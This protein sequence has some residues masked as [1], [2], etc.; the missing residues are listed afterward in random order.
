M[1]SDFCVS[2]YDLKTGKIIKMIKCDRPIIDAYIIENSG[3]QDVMLFVAGQIL[4]T[5]FIEFHLGTNLRNQ[6]Y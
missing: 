6:C 4:L 3:T 2:F 1:K 5:K